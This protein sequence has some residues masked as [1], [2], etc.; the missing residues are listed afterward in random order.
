MDYNSILIKKDTY[1]YFNKFKINEIYNFIINFLNEKNISIIDKNIFYSKLENYIYYKSFN[2]IKSKN[3]FCIEE[4]IENTEKEL[5]LD[6]D[7]DI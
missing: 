3:N 4:I 7:L 2:S 5:D 6:L 1:K